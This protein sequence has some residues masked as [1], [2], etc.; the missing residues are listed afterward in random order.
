[1]LE[2]LLDCV[3]IARTVNPSSFCLMEAMQFEGD[4]AARGCGCQI[5]MHIYAWRLDEESEDYV[6]ESSSLLVVE[7][8]TLLH[9]RLVS[10]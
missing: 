5:Y 8:E 6:H 10:C 4:V 3:C 1:M 2:F 9:H 7:K